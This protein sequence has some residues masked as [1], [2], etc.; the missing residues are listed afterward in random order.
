MLPYCATQDV[1]AI[2]RHSRRATRLR[3]L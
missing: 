1:A 3:G 2:V